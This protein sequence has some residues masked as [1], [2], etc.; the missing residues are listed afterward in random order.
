MINVGSDNDSL[1]IL[2]R[3]RS[4]WERQIHSIIVF[5]KGPIKIE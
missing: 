5:E 4:H 1:K 2:I 3:F